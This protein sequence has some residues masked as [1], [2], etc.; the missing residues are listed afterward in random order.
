MAN[1]PFQEWIDGVA[2][3]IIN[4]N[5]DRTFKLEEAAQAHE[6]MEANKVSSIT[7]LQFLSVSQKVAI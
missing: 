3:G 1:V 7:P 2:K 4:T 5:L 6:Y